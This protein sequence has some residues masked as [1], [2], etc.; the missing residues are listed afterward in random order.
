MSSYTNTGLNGA[1][2]SFWSGF[3]G[4][5]DGSNSST[6]GKRIRKWLTA[7]VGLATG[8]PAAAA[9]ALLKNSNAG[10]QINN[11][12]DYTPTA[13]ELPVFNAYKNALNN[14]VSDF[15]SNLDNSVNQ[16]IA[17]QLSTFNKQIKNLQIIRDYFASLPQNNTLSNAANDFIG[18]MVDQIIYSLEGTIEELLQANGITYTKTK[19]PLGTN[20][21]GGV[22]PIALQTA[23]NYPNAIGVQYIQPAGTTSRPSVLD[24]T[25]INAD[26]PVNDRVDV[27]TD[28]PDNNLDKEQDH[29]LRNIALTILGVV[30]IKKIFRKKSSIKN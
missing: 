28:I 23:S 3:F 29:T 22:I 17:T 4:H 18:R 7:A 25:E 30:L 1:W 10:A 21:I 8:N 2:A 24:Y 5:S 14:L 6:W 16:P 26:N 19:G 15:L 11:S 12:L 13:T 27:A 20:V 9:G